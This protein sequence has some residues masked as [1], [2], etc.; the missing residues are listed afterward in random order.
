MPSTVLGK[1][2]IGSLVVTSKRTSRRSG[3]IK[4]LLHIRERELVC[5]VHVVSIRRYIIV[6]VS[7]IHC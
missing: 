3:L 5:L 1:S 7:N 4:V 6:G 2:R